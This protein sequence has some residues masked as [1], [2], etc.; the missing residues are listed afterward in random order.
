MDKAT[1]LIEL[2]DRLKNLSKSDMT[3]SLGFYSEIIEDRIEEGM[4]EQEAVNGLG[5]IDEIAR[6]VMIDAT[7]LPKFAFTIMPFSKKDVPLLVVSSPLLVVFLGL[8]LLLYACIWFVI[9]SLYLIDIS[10]WVIGVAAIIGSII[11]FPED[12]P[13]SLLM[14]VGGLIC[15]VVGLLAFSP[16]RKGSMKM[17]SL[18]TRVSKKTKSIFLKKE[19]EKI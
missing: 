17:I 11:N 5:N 13:F 8:T 15:L 6:E 1:F 12:M 9:I 19:V 3:K 14:F 2:E 10:F 18:T 16:I 7:P 4:S